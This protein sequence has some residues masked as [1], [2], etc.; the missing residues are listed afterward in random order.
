MLVKENARSE[1]KGSRTRAGS[2]TVCMGAMPEA[3]S[4]PVM[5]PST[6]SRPC[7]AKLKV[8]QNQVMILHQSVSDQVL[9]Y[10]QLVSN[11]KKLQF[12]RQRIYRTI[13]LECN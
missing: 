7:N 8:K 2:P 11:V 4:Y 10:V 9:L 3:D 13:I 12:R 6:H 5:N 1:D